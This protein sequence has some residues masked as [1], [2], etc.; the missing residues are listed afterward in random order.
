MKVLFLFLDGVGIGRKDPSVNPLFAARLPAIRSLLGGALPSL[1]NRRIFTRRAALF[2][3]DATLGVSGLPQSGTG[4]TALFTGENASKLIG[5]HFGPHP[6]STL[7]PVIQAKNIFGVLLRSGLKPYFANAFPQKFFDYAAEHESRLTVT[8]QSCMM[9]GIPLSSAADLRAGKAVSA[10]I[11]NVGWPQMGYPEISEITPAEAGRRLVGLT[12]DYDFVLF[13]YWKTDHAGHSRN[14]DE[15]VEVLERFDGMLAGVIDAT[16]FRNTC[17][18][19]TS[20][21]GNIEDLRTKSH[22]RNPV[23]LLLAGGGR[24]RFERLVPLHADLTCVP[25]IV[26]RILQIPVSGTMC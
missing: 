18:M 16:D 26:T 2:P 24:P 14:R 22:T 6:Y 8:T 21:H 25:S 7:R 3:L 17:L 12:E 23:P 15:A 1:R 11:T 5:R 4:Q 19:L 13:E 10:D 9:S 20:D